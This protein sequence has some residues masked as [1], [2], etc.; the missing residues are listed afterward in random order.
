MNSQKTLSRESIAR[1]IAGKAVEQLKKDGVIVFR[2]PPNLLILSLTKQECIELSQ[3]IEH[4]QKDGNW[5]P[6]I[7]GINTKLLDYLKEIGY[8]N[9]G[10]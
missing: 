3:S 1:Q 6:Y 8:Y 7:R 4:A 9:A 5:S 10:H 2:D